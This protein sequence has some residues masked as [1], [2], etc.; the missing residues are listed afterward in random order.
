MARRQKASLKPQKWATSSDLLWIAE[1]LE[2]FYFRLRG[3]RCSFAICGK[4]GICGSI[5]CGAIL[6]CVCMYIL[7]FV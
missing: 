3:S 6:V 5:P 7:S 2:S 4:C 1:K